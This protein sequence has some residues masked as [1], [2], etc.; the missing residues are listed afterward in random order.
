METRSS[1]RNVLIYVLMLV[2]TA[3]V[4]V[5]SLLLLVSDADRGD[6]FWLTMGALLVAEFAGFLY[7]IIHTLRGEPKRAGFPFSLGAGVV[8]V[9][10]VGGVGVLALVALSQITFAAMLVL[11]LVW[12]LL[13]LLGTGAFIMGTSFVG[14]L[15][16]THKQQRAN[17][18]AVKEQFAALMDRVE[19]LQQ[20]G[21]EP[22]RDAMKSTHEALAY[23]ASESLPRSE[24]LDDELFAV[25][26]EMDQKTRELCN[27]C[28]KAPGDQN[29]LKAVSDVASSLV[30]DTRR[31]KGILN[32][33]E[34]L[35]AQLR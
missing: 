16:A 32:Q 30:M 28:D 5:A 24:G 1:S 29:C 33:R 2:L 4:T 15:T 18:V 10:Y 7:P 19:M 35:M 13:F 14:T 17:L 12:L 11:H 20:K 31:V 25:L 23:V 26:G 27:L 6:K 3:G 9:I 8:T 34:R 22:L 21:A